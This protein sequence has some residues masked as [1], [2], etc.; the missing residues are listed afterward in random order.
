[1]KLTG[2]FTWKFELVRVNTVSIKRWED[3]E[4]WWKDVRYYEYKLHLVQS[5][6]PLLIRRRNHVFIFQT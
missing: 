2:H 1:M 5:I 4:E 6:P 3:G